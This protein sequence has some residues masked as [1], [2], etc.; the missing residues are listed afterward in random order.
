MNESMEPMISRHA[1]V[2]MQQRGVRYDA[3]DVLLQ[4][5]REHHDHRGAVVLML[6]R[7]STRRLTRTGKARGP[8][9][10]MLRG[11]YAVVAA[12]GTVCT[13]GH[14]TRRLRRH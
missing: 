14:R 2:R 6:D 1:R 5:G 12:D 7:S 9:V 13:V 11:L 3:L 10:E 4:F 8:Q